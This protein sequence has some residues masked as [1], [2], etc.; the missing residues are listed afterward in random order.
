MAPRALRPHRAVPAPPPLRHGP[1]PRQDLR[2]QGAPGPVRGVGIA[3]SALEFPLVHS[4]ACDAGPWRLLRGLGMSGCRLCGPT[5]A[6]L[7]L[8]SPAAATHDIFSWSPSR[9]GSSSS[10]RWS[11]QRGGVRGTFSSIR[12]CQW[13]S[14][15]APARVRLPKG[16]RLRGRGSTAAGSSRSPDAAPGLGCFCE[17]RCALLPSAPRCR[18]C[19]WPPTNHPHELLKPQRAPAARRSP[20]CAP[21]LAHPSPG[22][23]AG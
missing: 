12:G 11:S 5:S 19:H 21:P 18:R 2:V 22:Q 1:R 6:E 16:G 13:R 15:C 14:W 10:C 3:W 9:G 4:W 23:R 7:H 8:P 17:I 20:T